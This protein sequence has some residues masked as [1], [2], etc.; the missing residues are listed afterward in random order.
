MIKKVLFTWELGAGLGHLSPIYSVAKKFHSKGYEIWIA[1]QFL[2][3]VHSVFTDIP[4]HVI[5]GPT[6]FN[7]EKN[8]PIICYAD[9]LY[10]VGY[11]DGKELTVFIK[12]WKNI[13]QLVQ[14]DIIVHDYSPT[15]MLASRE[16]ECEKIYIG[17]TFSN[18]ASI[19]IRKPEIQTP[20]FYHYLKSNQSLE[21]FN[22]HS[23]VIERKVLNNINMALNICKIGQISKITDIYSDFSKILYLTLP[24]LDHYQ[25]N[26]YSENTHFLVSS[27]I[28]TST[29]VN[30]P[31][32]EKSIK[33][34][35]YL[36]VKSYSKDALV[37][38]LNALKDKRFSSIL[39]LSGS[40]DINQEMPNNIKIVNKPINI[41]M[42]QQQADILLCNSN[43]NSVIDFL[44][45]GTPI[46]L[47][48]LTPE[49]EL[50]TALLESKGYGFRLGKLS[51]EV[52][53]QLLKAKNTKNNALADKYS[54]IDFDKKLDELLIEY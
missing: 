11:S 26:E 35:G 53:D 1:S 31:D 20:R 12:S 6:N 24:E 43:L 19:D 25:R 32:D 34:F 7:T 41:S 27:G 3:N 23:E 8:N 9:I 14:P 2:D 40:F 51:S 42:M 30:W 50:L 28:Q 29:I 52:I 5:Q 45:S 16:Y 38:L 44:M 39:Y 18:L 54:S 22:Q 13:Y 48:P 47:L 33:V 10:N 46:G 49:Q 17:S 15:A 36:K 37:S 21:N 4:V